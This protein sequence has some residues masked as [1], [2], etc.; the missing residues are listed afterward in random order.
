MAERYNYY[1]E[2]PLGGWEYRRRRMQP[3]LVPTDIPYDKNHNFFRY[4]CGSRTSAEVIRTIA[5]LTVNAEW[6]DTYEAP[7]SIRALHNFPV[8]KFTIMGKT[9]TSNQNLMCTTFL[10]KKMYLESRYEYCY[11]NYVNFGSFE[12][13][14]LPIYSYATDTW[15]EDYINSTHDIDGR[16]RPYEQCQNSRLMR[17]KGADLLTSLT[18]N[19]GGHM[20]VVYPE[21]NSLY[22]VPKPYI[23]W[24]ETFRKRDPIPEFE[25]ILFGVYTFTMPI[26]S[27]STIYRNV[28]NDV[29]DMGRYYMTKDYYD[30][31]YTAFNPYPWKYYVLKSSTFDTMN[32]SYTENKYNMPADYIIRDKM[33][34]TCTLEHCINTIIDY[35]NWHIRH[36]LACTYEGDIGATLNENNVLVHHKY[37]NKNGIIWP[38]G[39]EWDILKNSVCDL[40]IGDCDHTLN[41]VVDYICEMFDLDITA[42]DYTNE[43][44]SLKVELGMKENYDVSTIDFGINLLDYTNDMDVS[45]VVTAVVPYMT[46]FSSDKDTDSGRTFILPGADW[47]AEYIPEAPYK[48]DDK[49][50]VLRCKYV[51]NDKLVE[52]YGW[53]T[54]SVEFDYTNYDY[55]KRYCTEAD[56]ER[57]TIRNILQKLGAEY[58]YSQFNKTIQTF[59]ISAVDMAYL[60]GSDRTW[61]VGDMIRC[62]SEPHNFNKVLPITKV[63][64]DLLDPANN[65]YTIGQVSVKSLT[66][67]VGERTNKKR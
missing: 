24:R 36:V 46:N 52:L 32:T 35:Y 42:Y 15:Y 63:E 9:N 30:V 66:R 53:V 47:H 5:E 40:F 49:G 61:E 56:Q 27:T 20:N 1:I 38:D 65:V 43:E 60:T 31:C 62:K 12:M 45:D 34:G 67:W 50:D 7:L 16:I 54:D 6:R 21:W 10:K 57:V 44:K 58:L 48:G 64:L 8:P 2:T 28:T 39:E 33:I 23:V 41:D 3:S 14:P 51:S 59:T 55:I 13:A 25:R 37:F 17:E 11:N 26:Q 29:S 22:E 4:R 19:H 18:T